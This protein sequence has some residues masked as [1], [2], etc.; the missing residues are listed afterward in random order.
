MTD[1]EFDDGIPAHYLKDG[2]VI[3]YRLLLNDG[4]EVTAYPDP[5]TRSGIQTDWI[6]KGTSKKIKD[7]EV[8]GWKILE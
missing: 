3:W 2:R 1:Q 6:Q 7:E 8:K 4:N 5:I